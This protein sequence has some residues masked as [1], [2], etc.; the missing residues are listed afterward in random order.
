MLCWQ[1]KSNYHQEFHRFL[2]I[3]NAKEINKPI[4]LFARRVNMIDSKAVPFIYCGEIAFIDVTGNN[5]VNVNFK[6]KQCIS[7]A[8]EQEFLKIS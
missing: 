2:E 6:L 8:L 3:R 4:Q 1:S 7:G 5:P